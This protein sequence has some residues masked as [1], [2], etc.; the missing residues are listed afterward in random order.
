MT[1]TQN[2]FHGLAALG[3]D[4]FRRMHG[5]E[6]L[7]GG[8]YHVDRVGRPVTLRQ[9]VLHTCYFQYGTHRATG[10]DTRTFGSRLHEDLGATMLSLDRILQSC[11]VEGNVDHVFP[12]GFHRFLDSYRHFPGLA[13]TEA[14]TTF[15]ITNHSQRGECEDTATLHYLGNAIDLNQL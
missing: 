13:A 15:T 9:H 5:L 1:S 2:I 4:I 7:D 8:T 11:P 6:T 12:R 3:C 10:D 14:D